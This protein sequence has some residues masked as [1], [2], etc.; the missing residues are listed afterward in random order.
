MGIFVLLDIYNKN[1]YMNKK[2][3]ITEEQYIKLKFRLL[4]TKFDVLANKI[5][6][7]G[8]I[9]T[10]VSDGKKIN[11]KVFDS[12]GGNLY[13]DNID[14]GSEYYQKRVFLLSTSLLDN[15]NLEIKVAND[16]QKNETPPKGNTWQKMVLK[17]IEDVYVTRNGDVIDGINFDE[18]GKN[19]KNLE[20]KNEFLKLLSDLNDGETLILETDK[21][22]ITLVYL[23]KEGNKY[24]FNLSKKTESE[25]NNSNVEKIELPIDKINVDEKGNVNIQ[26]IE[27]I[28]VEGGEGYD[29]YIDE[30]VSKLKLIS[31]EIGEVTPEDEKETEEKPEEETEVNPEEEKEIDPKKFMEM[32]SGDAQL[33]AAF[34]SKP[35]FFQSF[36]AELNSENPNEK[37]TGYVLVKNLLDDYADKKIG[38]KLGEGWKKTGLVVFAPLETIELPYKDTKGNRQ[39]FT[40][41]SK[42]VYGRRFQEEGVIRKKNDMGNYGD[43]E[44]TLLNKKFNFEIVVKEKTDDPDVFICDV[45]KLYTEPSPENP[46]KTIT[47]ESE[48]VKDVEI[49]FLQSVGYVSEENQ[50]K[51]EEK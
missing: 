17:K 50:E 1:T 26:L 37:A 48:P 16:N 35:S 23:S 41:Q 39:I 27:H 38:E 32:L 21:L 49:K 40:L 4:E 10:I 13:V 45:I 7:K 3:I 24:I 33:R 34:Y 14:K 42:R 5:I 9:L 47:A 11:F 46:R 31:T 2:L 30:R 18:K 8:D 19:N 29:E 36:W 20:K 28:K 25:I 51:K 43:Y 22:T 6:N 44:I 12:Y 15:G